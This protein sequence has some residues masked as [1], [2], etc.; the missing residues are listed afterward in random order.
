MFISLSLN[1]C[2]DLNMEVDA[3][4]FDQPL[5]AL[6]ERKRAGGKGMNIAI[7]LGILGMEATA[8]AVVAGHSGAEF[9][10]LA[11]EAMEPLPVRL[12]AVYVPGETRTNTVLT[13]CGSAQHLKVNQRGQAL[14]ALGL[15]RVFT[16]LD[17]LVNRGDIL[18]LSG[19]LPP[20]ALGATYA[21]LGKRYAK[22]GCRIVLDADGEALKGG[23]LV[24]PYLVKPNR[25]E[26]AVFAGRPLE[27]E[28]DIIAA[29]RKMLDAGAEM[30]LVSD[31]PRPAF[32]ITNEFVLRGIPPEASGSPSGAGDAMLAGFLAAGAGWDKADIATGIEIQLLEQKNEGVFVKEADRLSAC[33]RLALACGSAAASMPDT[34]YCA[35]D[36]VKKKLSAGK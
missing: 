8:V 11:G 15:Q 7:I 24:R 34:M 4:S 5:R 26:L 20:G 9:C 18:I 31:G 25:D 12:E 16:S 30:C 23:L 17:G 22:R 32:L 1:P 2:I 13:A 27:T 29:A 3:F 33:F 36:D 6:S 19:S 21:V 10:D 35:W 14:S 28:Q